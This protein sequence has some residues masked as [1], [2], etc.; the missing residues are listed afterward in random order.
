MAFLKKLWTK[1]GLKPIELLIMAKGGLP[2]TI[3]LAFYQ[4]QPVANTFTTLGYLVAIISI[5][6]FCI[7]PRARFLQ[8]LLLNLLSS[9]IGAAMAL[10]M[11]FCTVQARLHTTTPAGEL[12]SGQQSPTPGASL[13]MY[14]S[15]ASA[16]SAIWLFF[17][18]YLVNTIKA[19]YPQFNFP[20]IMY[21]IFTIVAATYSPQF[22]T[23][24]AGESFVQRLLEA[25]LTGL[26]LATGVSL[27]ILPT[28]SRKVVFV[29]FTMYFGQLKGALDTYKKWLEAM[30]TPE[31]MSKLVSAREPGKPSPVPEAEA[32][33]KGVQGLLAIHGK[34]QTDMTFAKREVALGKLGP[35]DL[36]EMNKK[37]RS[38]MLPIVGLASLV[39]IFERLAESRGWTEEKIKEG[40]DAEDEE[41]RNDTISGWSATMKIIHEPVEQI[42]TD[43]K[44]GMDHI[45]LR[46][47][48]K[49]PE[50]KGKGDKSQDIEDEAQSTRPGSDGFADYLEKRSHA[51]HNGKEEA[52]RDW[53]K[54]KGIEL[55]PNFFEHPETAKF[56]ESEETR[57]E[58]YE[59]HQ[60]RQRQLYALLYIEYL[61]YHTSQAILAFVRFA[62][63]RVASGK[64]DKT[65]LVVPGWKRMRKWAFSVFKEEDDSNEHELS[66]TQTSENTVSLGDAYKDKR[67]PE[68]LPP[69]NTIE[70]IGNFIR[71][72]PNFFRSS[73]SAFGLR[74][75]IA[76]MCVGI[77]NYLADTQYFFTQNRLLWAMIMIAI[78]MT[79]TA[80]KTHPV[81]DYFQHANN[82]HRPERFQLPMPYWWH[83]SR[84]GIEFDH[85]LHRRRPHSRHDRLLLAVRIFPFLHHS[86]EAC[87]C[88]RRNDLDRDYLLDHRLRAGG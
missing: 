68:H 5:I 29:D 49:K 30:Q 39:T 56:Y 42:M 36:K 43:M 63:E 57:S 21:S 17:Q 65:R 38:V 67:D 80:G 22:P 84:F 77:V 51:F 60:R 23:M 66:D 9:C 7:M 25:F 59:R 53:C 33:K 6:G 16:V 28:T 2:P 64:L 78:S 82:C 4:A 40:L 12:P 81:R 88:S 13:V 8:T 31:N 79:P 58:T 69:S 75:A 20:A 32:V 46:L 61:L 27:F 72:I 14:N 3:A 76:T 54:R 35:D 87:L 41:Y 71:I 10:L 74:A 73:E 52:L 26:A 11:I 1:T 18:I 83:G 48:L 19:K 47:E 50:E 86:Q 37:I 44:D 85:L 55:P 24:A 15:S 62:D 70:K 45:M 34:L